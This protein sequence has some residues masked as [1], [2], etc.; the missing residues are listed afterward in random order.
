[1]VE[2][3]GENR[4]KIQAILEEIKVGTKHIFGSRLKGLLLYGSYARGDA[5]SESD[6]DL[7]LIL[8]DLKDPFQ[9]R[10]KYAS[11]I[12]NL[13]LKYNVLISI[14][15]VDENQYSSQYYPLFMNVRREGVP[16]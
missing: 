14:I 2:I 4:L 10:E 11:F 6:I 8:K 5:S 1:M 13:D 9:E 16:V 7:M 12:C 3:K 15:P